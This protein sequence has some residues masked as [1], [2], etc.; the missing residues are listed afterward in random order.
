ML[1]FLDV[2]TTGLNQ[3]TLL[4]LEIAAVLV[5]DQLRELGRFAQ[6]LRFPPHDSEPIDPVVVTMHL[7]NGLWGECL[8]SA[9]TAVDVDAELVAW[10]SMLGAGAGYGAKQ[11]HLNLAGASVHFDREVLRRHFPLTR[12][13]LHHRQVDTSSLNELA[14]RLAPAAYEARPRTAKTAHRALPDALESLELARYY[15][16]VLG[17]AAAPIVNT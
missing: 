13:L 15:G 8:R 6:V 12:G 4:P 17:R 5:D 11:S 9:R 14:R 10:L 7:T 3:D 2:E 1:L 16:G